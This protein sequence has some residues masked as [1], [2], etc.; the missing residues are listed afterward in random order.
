MAVRPTS[1]LNH[2]FQGVT[3]ATTT[4]EAALL[5]VANEMARAAL[6]ERAAM[7]EDPEVE[8][9]VMLEMLVKWP[10]KQGIR[11]LALATALFLAKYDKSSPTFRSPWSSL[12]AHWNMRRFKEDSTDFWHTIRSSAHLLNKHA[13]IIDVLPLGSHTT[14]KVKVLTR[15]LGFKASTLDL[16]LWNR[17]KRRSVTSVLRRFLTPAVACGTIRCDSK[18]PYY[19]AAISGAGGW[20]HQDVFDAKSLQVH[21]SAVAMYTGGWPEDDYTIVLEDEVRTGA[22]HVQKK[23][24]KAGKTK[25]QTQGQKKQKIVEEEESWVDAD[26]EHEHLLPLWRGILGGILVLQVLEWPRVPQGMHH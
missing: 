1:A 13:P 3:T 14:D 17:G 20:L 22:G 21:H 5:Q 7:S 8:A 18:Y 9:E 6:L 2:S 19:L 4:R 11:A 16:V 26:A 15:L 23:K 10:S 25:R 24:N 12:Y